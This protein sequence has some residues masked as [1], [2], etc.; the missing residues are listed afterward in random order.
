M[1][2][3]R[4]MVALCLVASSASLLAAPQP[5]EAPGAAPSAAWKPFQEFGFLLGNWSG[6]A[7]A[8]KR[9]G[10][11]VVQVGAEMDANYISFRGMRLF[12]EQDGRPEE[13]V[14]ETGTFYYDRDKR[15]YGAHLYFSSGIV[16]VFDVE[17]GSGMV[18]LTSRDIVNYEGARSRITLSKT[19]E[20]IL[21]VLEFAPP[22]KEF[23]PLYSAKLSRR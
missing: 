21:Y 10:G 7:E 12:P 20:G 15:R 22:G 14:E 4:L 13:T 3:S 18:K 23:V 5:A 2:R 6:I 19:P 1:L 9:I 16:G 8:G 11:S 17:A